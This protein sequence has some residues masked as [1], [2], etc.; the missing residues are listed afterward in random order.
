MIPVLVVPSTLGSRETEERKTSN[1]YGL[2][3]FGTGPSH[4][5]IHFGDILLAIIPCLLLSVENEGACKRAP[6]NG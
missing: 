2:L 1:P 4:P 5:C 3:S 6:V